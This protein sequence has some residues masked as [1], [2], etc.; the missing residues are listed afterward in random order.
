[1]SNMLVIV[2]DTVGVIAPEQLIKTLVHI[3]I[4]ATKVTAL[5]DVGVMPNVVSMLLP[6]GCY[7]NL[8]N[9]PGL[10]MFNGNVF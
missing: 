10:K 9:Y 6:S 1:M 5:P 3:D 7:V 4:R 2:D 8:D